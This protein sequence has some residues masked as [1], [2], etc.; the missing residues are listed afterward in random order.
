MKNKDVEKNIYQAFSKLEVDNDKLLHSILSDCKKTESRIVVMEE[1]N[2]NIWTNG[3]VRLALAFALLLGIFF[4]YNNM[5]NANS[6]NNTVASTISLDVNPS[7]EIKINKD[8]KV[9][10]VVA[11]NEDAISIIG[12]MDFKGS[13]L[14]V[15][16]NALIGSLVRNGY[17]NEL[18]NSILI[19]VENKNADEALALE[20]RLMQEISKIV[21]NSSI[22]YQS[23]NTT[24]EIKELAQKYGITEGKAQLVKE[25]VDASTIYEYEDLAGLNINELNLLKKNNETGIQRT[26]SPSDKAYVG[27]DKAKEVA[28]KHAGFNE[29]DVLMEKTELDYEMQKMVYEVEF[30]HNGIE[31][32]YVIDATTGEIIQNFSEKDDDYYVAPSTN[33][34]TNSNTGN[35]SKP[36]STVNNSSSVSEAQAKQ[37]ALSHAGVKESDVS[38]YRVEKEYDDG[39]L[40]YEI[41]FMVGNVEYDYEVNANTGAIIK[42]ESE[43]EDD[44]VAPSNNQAS[45][46]T[47]AQTSPA[48][49]TQNPPAGTTHVSGDDAYK[50]ENGQVYEYDDDTNTWE[51]EPEK[52]I[53]NGT[54]YEQENGQ[55]QPEEKTENGVTYEYEE[56]T[57]TWEPEE[58]VENGVTYEY[59]DD[60]N[61]WEA[62]EKV[63]NGQK[64]EYDD[65]T[66][67]WEVDDDDDHDDHDDD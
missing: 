50:V 38:F 18:A 6:I 16:V 64:L 19:S 39:V 17:I 12:D 62:E 54:V 4:T 27:S 25:I 13:N 28:L 11:K 7:I 59:D 22:L 31:Y 35:Q 14:N 65:D 37:A 33:N 41:D 56:H 36:S 67:T 63:E 9:L 3:F 40:K 51:A 5:N 10:D 66:G 49:A 24:D 30:T 52:K 43:V 60:T 53:E 42:A 46:P 26:G 45:T 48:P 34:N 1:K 61:T 47:P 58:K 57:N 20:E 55:W 15:T 29:A 2:N 32:D 44:H 23:L 21:E 8:E